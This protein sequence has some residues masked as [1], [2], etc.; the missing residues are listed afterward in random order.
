MV[1][2]VDCV[3]II[4]VAASIIMDISVIMGDC[5]HHGFIVTGVGQL[6]WNVTPPQSFK[7][8]KP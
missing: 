7:N 5:H 3:A 2:A 6:R 8:P 4:T 1:M